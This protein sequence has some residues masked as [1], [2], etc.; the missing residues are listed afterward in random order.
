M[1]LLLCA[2]RVIIDV[3]QQYLVPL[4]TL[5]SKGL[6]L[7]NFTGRFGN[8]ALPQLDAPVYDAA[9]YDIF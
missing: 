1:L 5:N 6:L 3:L 9:L 8:L 7:L 2:V 4:L